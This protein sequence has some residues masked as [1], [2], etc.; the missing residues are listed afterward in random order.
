[1]LAQFK[2]GDPGGAKTGVAQSHKWQA[3]IVVTA[4]GGPCKSIVGYVPIPM[5]WPEQT[6]KVCQQEVSP[7]VK[8]PIRPSTKRPS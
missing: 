7:G 3:G 2:E 4:T 8:Q 1:M 5:E 6:V